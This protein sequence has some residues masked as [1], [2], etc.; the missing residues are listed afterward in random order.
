[1]RDASFIKGIVR[2][3]RLISVGDMNRSLLAKACEQYKVE[4]GPLRL[5]EQDKR[6]KNKYLKT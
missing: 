5:S 6:I 1:M 4:S 2:P 3:L